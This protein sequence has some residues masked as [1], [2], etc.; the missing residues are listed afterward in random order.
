MAAIM[1]FITHYR[2]LLPRLSMR[3]AGISCLA[4]SDMTQTEMQDFAKTFPDQRDGLKGIKCNTIFD[5]AR[6]GYQGP[7]EYTTMYLCIF[8]AGPLYCSRAH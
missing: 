6:F 3:S 7:L 4:T 1:V 5:V 2:L 8:A